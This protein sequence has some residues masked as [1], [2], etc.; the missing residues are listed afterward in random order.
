VKQTACIRR[1]VALAIGLLDR[2]LDEL[3]GDA[4]FLVDVSILLLGRISLG[5]VTLE[6][7]I[8][9]GFG[10]PLSSWPPM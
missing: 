7:P 3:V 4:L 8:K 1:A 2:D 5:S 6:Q 10:K 9:L